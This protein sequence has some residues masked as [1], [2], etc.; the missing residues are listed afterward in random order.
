LLQIVLFF[1]EKICSTINPKRH[2]IAKSSQPMTIFHNLMCSKE[3]SAA[4]KRKF[5]I[6]AQHDLYCYALSLIQLAGSFD[7]QTN[8]LAVIYK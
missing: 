2:F 7:S 8:M 3:K 4:M 1:L 6:N 5:V